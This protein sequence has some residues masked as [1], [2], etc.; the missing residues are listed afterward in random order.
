MALADSPFFASLPAHDIER[1]K[2]WYADKLGLTPTTDLGVAGQLYATGG[3][4]WLIYQ[5][6]SAGTAKNTLGGW[7][8]SDIDA[9]M[10][11]L[12][13]KGVTFE[14]YAL[15]DQGPTTENGVSRDPS[16]G[17]SAWFVDSEGNIL[18]ITQLPPG[19]SMT[20]GS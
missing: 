5:T 12:R 15:G 14:E 8:V 9:T 1:A 20:G 18:A 10:A 4:Q 6:P 17:A 2:R 7:A 16:G 11:E 13:A 19:M 3:V